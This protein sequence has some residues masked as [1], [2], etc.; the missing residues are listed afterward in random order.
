MFSCTSFLYSLNSSCNS[1]SAF[2]ALSFE[3]RP[4]DCGLLVCEPGRFTGVLATEPVENM[5]LFKSF[6]SL[7]AD[8]FANTLSGRFA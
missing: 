3:V 7:N 4:A 8:G 1:T 6:W 2:F 5:L